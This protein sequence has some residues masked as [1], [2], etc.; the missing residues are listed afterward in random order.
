MPTN[1]VMASTLLKIHKMLRTSFRQ[2]AA[3]VVIL[4]L[5]VVKYA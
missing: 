3:I 1:K 4:F 2:E 5:C